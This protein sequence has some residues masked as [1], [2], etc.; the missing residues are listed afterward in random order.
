MKL[1][2]TLRGHNGDINALVVLPNGDLA[3]GSSDDTIK[4]WNINSGTL[5]ETLFSKDTGDVN[6]LVV[7]QNGDLASGSTDNNIRIWS[8]NY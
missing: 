2:V 1:K 3:S 6:A 8:N 4:I 5:K 7:L